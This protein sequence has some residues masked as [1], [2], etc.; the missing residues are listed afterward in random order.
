M[1]GMGGSK[2]KMKIGGA[3]ALRMRANKHAMF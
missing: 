1:N 3:V 2:G